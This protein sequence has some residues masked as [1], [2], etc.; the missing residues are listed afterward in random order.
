VPTRVFLLIL[1]AVAAV[2]FFGARLVN[3]DYVF[4]AG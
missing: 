4:F 3:N 1:I 2:V